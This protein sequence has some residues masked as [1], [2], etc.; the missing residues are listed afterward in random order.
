MFAGKCLYIFDCL[1]ASGTKGWIFMIVSIMALT[2]FIK[3][4]AEKQT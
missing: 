4:G 1:A 2:H 3:R